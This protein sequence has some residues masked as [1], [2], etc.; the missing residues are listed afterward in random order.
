MGM[1]DRNN[2]STN[3]R[4]TARCRRLEYRMFSSD[5]GRKNVWSSSNHTEV[6]SKI[7]QMAGRYWGGVNKV[8]YVLNTSV[9]SG[10]FAG[11]RGYGKRGRRIKSILLDV[12]IQQFF[13]A[14]ISLEMLLITW[15]IAH[16]KEDRGCPRFR[17]TSHGHG[18]R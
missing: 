5:R 18:M 4:V 6:L 1:R 16:W 9:G 7:T 13:V 15:G 12:K 2:G 10:N 3:S 17:V 8:R 14:Q 11:I